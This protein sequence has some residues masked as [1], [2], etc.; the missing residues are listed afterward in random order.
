M[1]TTFK[2]IHTFIGILAL[3]FFIIQCNEKRETSDFDKFTGRW[4]LYKIQLQDTISKNWNNATGN[5]KNRN[6]FIIY[7]GLEG[8]GVYHVTENYENFEFEGKGSLDSLT[9]KYGH[10]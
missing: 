7:D 2:K 5:N 10:L 9:K 1:E 8:M 6:G 3:P 4:K